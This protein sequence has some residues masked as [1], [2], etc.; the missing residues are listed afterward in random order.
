MQNVLKSDTRVSKRA[1][2]SVD[3]AFGLLERVCQRVLRTRVSKH[4][5]NQPLSEYGFAYGLKTEMCQFSNHFLVSPTAKERKQI[6]SE[7]RLST[8]SIVSKYGL[9]WSAVRFGLVPSTILLSS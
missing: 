4:V 1:L 8:V 9:D 3:M 7:H 2:E 6:L 5:F